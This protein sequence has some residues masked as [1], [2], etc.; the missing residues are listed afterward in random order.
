VLPFNLPRTER[1]ASTCLRLF[2]RFVR[3][4]LNCETTDTNTLRLDMS[5]PSAKKSNRATRG[6]RQGRV[7]NSQGVLVPIV[8]L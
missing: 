4:S 3:S 2:T 6:L 1:A 7:T 5:S 8:S